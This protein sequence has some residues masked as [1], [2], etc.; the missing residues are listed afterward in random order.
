[1]SMWDTIQAH[2]EEILAS[3]KRHGIKDVRV[4]GSVAR[5]DERPESDVDFLVNRVENTRW[6]GFMH[7]QEEVESLLHCKADVV[8]EQALHRLI[9]NS[10]LHEARLL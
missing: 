7:F 3:A 9:K 1:M 6:Y 5:G 4:F 8:T 2:R 10:I